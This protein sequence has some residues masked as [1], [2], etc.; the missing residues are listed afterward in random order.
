M[1]TQYKLKNGLEVILLENHKSQVVS[2]QAWVRTGSAN[3]IPAERGISHFLEHLVFK[4]SKDFGV[5]EI[6]SVVE[7]SGGHMNAYTSFHQTVYYVTLSSEFLEKGLQVISNLVGYPTLVKEEIDKEREVVLEEIRQGEDSLRN[8]GGRL[9]FKTAC[10]GEPYE[11]P[12]IGY[13]KI[14]KEVTPETIKEYHMQRY[15][16]KNM[17]LLV[18]GDIDKKNI[19]Q[20]IEKNFG[21][22]GSVKASDSSNDRATGVSKKIKIVA[23]TGK[24]KKGLPVANAQKIHFIDY[25]P[26]EKPQT[27]SK[28]IIA[29]EKKNFEKTLFYM[30]WP[31]PRQTHKDSPALDI[32]SSVLGQG[33]SS[34][35]LKKLRLEKP[36]VFSVGAYSYS[37]MGLFIISAT[38]NHE[39]LQE[40]LEVIKGEILNMFENGITTDEIKNAVTAMLADESYSLETSD[41]LARKLGNLKFYYNDLNY[42]EKYKKLV[43]KLTEKDILNAAEKYLTSSCPVVTSIA[44]DKNHSAEEI[45]KKWTKSLVNELK[46]LKKRKSKSAKA[47]P[48]IIKHPKWPKNVISA[49]EKMQ[50]YTFKD[51]TRIFLRPDRTTPIVSAKFATLGG[52][53]VE[54]G[55]R[56]GI[57]EVLERTW[58]TG[59]KSLS[60]LDINKRLDSMGTQ[61]G[62][63]CGKNSFGLSMDLLSGFQ[64]N[65]MEL[66]FD[67]LENPIFDGEICE[68]EK[69]IMNQQQIARKDSPSSLCALNFA[70]RMFAGHNYGS[71]NLGSEKSRSLITSGDILNMHAKYILGG[72]KHFSI[73]GNFDVKKWQRAIEDFCKKHKTK[74]HGLTK[75]MS[76]SKLD[77]D[78]RCFEYNKKEQSHLIIG[79]RGL[80]LEDERRYSLQVLQAVLDGMGGRLFVELRDKL[81]LAYSVSPMRME[82]IDAG[83]FGGYIA[84]APNKLS[85]AID[86]ML[87]EFEK[88]QTTL[89]S[90]EEIE[91]AKRFLIGTHD[92]ELQRNSAICASILY[93]DIYGLDYNEAF[94]FK[95]HIKEVT[96][97]SVKDLAN[98]LFSKPKIISIVGQSEK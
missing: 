12:V 45:T 41:G 34:R 5:G 96:A 74:E 64:E 16:P 65:A 47:S 10:K 48:K 73:C 36:L 13:E 15:S 69:H 7:A 92:I 76:L 51:G 85:T 58:T 83:Y 89:V 29:F 24:N 28:P 22:I 95:T 91:R 38:L 97:K 11:H 67:V 82:A 57:V 94:Q 52:I 70:S 44:P 20:M 37:D 43:L 68:R 61:L 79:W 21:G 50:V 2:V 71:D 25:K 55:D 6:A 75:K 1:A 23:K 30:S 3:E 63:V 93:N 87:L 35:L 40:A 86:K 66:F 81:S 33:E 59:T 8:A 14:I 39:N 9:L 72:Q 42:F 54:P 49:S 77:E 46:N 60:E 98:E 27:I 17:F 31:I 84:C 90:N 78:Q 53:R 80:T 19:K 26:R 18:T 32:F 62:S 4:G 88:I 56:G